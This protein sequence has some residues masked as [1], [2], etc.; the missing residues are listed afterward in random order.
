MVSQS[1]LLSD[2]NGSMGG[3][4]AVSAK[5]NKLNISFTG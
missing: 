1:Q 5:T 3:L 4:R 2:G